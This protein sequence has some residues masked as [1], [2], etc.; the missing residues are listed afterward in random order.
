ML[1]TKEQTTEDRSRREGEGV[2][3]GWKKRSEG[4]QRRKGLERARNRR[5][6]AIQRGPGPALLAEGLGLTH[7]VPRMAA[8]AYSG[9]LQG[10]C[11]A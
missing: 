8:F 11:F 6:S 3:G 7:L 4:G 9:R 10:G 2:M 5:R 1:A